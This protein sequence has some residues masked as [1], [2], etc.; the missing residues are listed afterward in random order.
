MRYIITF[1]SF[2]VCTQL[3]INTWAADDSWSNVFKFQSKMAQ[4][5]SVNAQLILGE[6]YEDGRGVK[7]SYPKAFQWYQKALSNGHNKAANR[8]TRLKQKIASEK[9][10]KSRPARPKRAVKTKP[11]A[12]IPAKKI[13]P[14]KVAVKAK[15]TV[16]PVT[17][18][19]KAE[20][21]AKIKINEYVH[22]PNDPIASPDDLERGKGTHLDDSEDP[23]D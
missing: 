5:G 21:E 4:S 12:I 2:I 1:L 20:V 7:K 10:A 6:M 14:V 23:F 13:K 9:L 15:K 11:R 8:I 18:K 19:A 17:V 3:S 22:N 16:K